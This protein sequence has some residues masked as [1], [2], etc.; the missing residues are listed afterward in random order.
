[1]A[2]ISQHEGISAFRSVGPTKVVIWGLRDR[3]E[4]VSRR[5]RPIS[6][7]RTEK[8]GFLNAKEM[9]RKAR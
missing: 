5:S 1:M 6:V 9:T 7:F 2:R 3:A 4:W 8:P